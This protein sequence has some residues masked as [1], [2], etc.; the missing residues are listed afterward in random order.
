MDFGRYIYVAIRPMPHIQNLYLF[1]IASLLFNLTPGNDMIY[2]A[3]RRI[4]Q[5]VKAGIISALGIFF[6]CF[7]H[8]LAAVFGLSLIL[9][10]SVFAFELIKFFGA[11]YLIY[12]GV[13]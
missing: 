4:T 6:G 3:S 13:K 2:M 11:A 5:G 12:L 1:F 10:K 8:I 9:A 7:A